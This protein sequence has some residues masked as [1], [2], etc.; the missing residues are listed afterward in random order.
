VQRAPQNVPCASLA[1]PG[2]REG[3]FQRGELLSGAGQV[4]LEELAVEGFLG[5]LCGD[6][7]FACHA[8]S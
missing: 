5:R 2:R 1:G 8:G 4:V 7:S 6:L 3:R